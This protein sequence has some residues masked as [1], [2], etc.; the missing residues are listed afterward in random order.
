MPATSWT[1]PTA[2]ISGDTL[3]AAHMNAIGDN[4]KF[5]KNVDRARV[6]Q[7]APQ[8]LTT[9]TWE[10]I[11]WDAE[12]YDTNGLHAGGSPTVLTSAT[13]GWYTV[14]LQVSFAADSFGRRD[15]Q[16]RKNDSSSDATAGSRWGRCTQ[17]SLG[18]SDSSIL[19]CFAE[20]YLSVGDYVKGC[21]WQNSGG[22]LDV[23][24]GSG[25]SWMSMTWLGD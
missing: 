8:G 25:T 13:D 14:K 11:S 7:T 2:F 19:Q 24:S 22:G 21:A 20:V 12:D 18:G 6:Y 16:I 23:E 15:I 10:H 4:L 5:L 17:G 9:A 3:N 1:A